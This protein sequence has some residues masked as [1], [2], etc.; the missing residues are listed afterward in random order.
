MS[1]GKKS[2]G[3]PMI[4]S[5]REKTESALSNGF[6]RLFFRD[7]QQG[8]IFIGFPKGLRTGFER[9][10]NG[11]ERVS[12]AHAEWVTT[13]LNGFERLRTAKVGPA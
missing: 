8:N 1:N 6:E 4:G 13:G 11:S 7:L 10:L 9:L 5:E 3:T 2:T 12:N